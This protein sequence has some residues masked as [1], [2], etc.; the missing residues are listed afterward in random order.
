MR[1]GDSGGGSGSIPSVSMPASVEIMFGLIYLG[2]SLEGTIMDM[3]LPSSI[4]YDRRWWLDIGSSIRHASIIAH[5]SKFALIDNGS[6][7]YLELPLQTSQAWKLSSSD[8]VEC[9]KD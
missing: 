2:P 9:N 5:A 6:I 1:G 4:K 8:V 7:I 3:T